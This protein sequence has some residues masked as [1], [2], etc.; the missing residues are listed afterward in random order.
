MITITVDISIRKQNKRPSSIWNGQIPHWPYGI[1]PF[2]MIAQFLQCCKI[3]IKFPPKSYRWTKFVLILEWNFFLKK[4][5]MLK[6]IWHSCDVCYVQNVKFFSFVRDKM[7]VFV[8]KHIITTTCE[9]SD[10]NGINGALWVDRFYWC[11]R[12]SG[13]SRIYACP[14]SLTPRNIPT[15]LQY[16]GVRCT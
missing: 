12:R 8:C 6:L 5:W 7:R 13:L 9:F 15:L 16:Q 11:T 10:W 1:C 14:G 2:A 4:I 3:K